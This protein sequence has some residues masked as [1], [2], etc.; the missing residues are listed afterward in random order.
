MPDGSPQTGACY[1]G[2][3]KFRASGPIRFTKLCHCKPCSRARGVSPVHILAV[4]AEGFAVTEGEE[5]VKVMPSPYGSMQH[6]FCSGCGSAIWQSPAPEKFRAL[7]PASFTLE[8]DSTK[9]GMLPA[10]YAPNTH[11]NYENRTY[12]WS[13]ALPKHLGFP[14]SLCENDG[15]PK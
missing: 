1:C 14:E 15:T 12:D 4:G 13:D 8:E 11:T 5:L 10:K 6:A 3:V 9:S 2:G 7:F